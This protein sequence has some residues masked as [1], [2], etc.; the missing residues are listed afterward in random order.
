MS[1]NEVTG[2]SQAGFSA[3]LQTSC[4]AAVWHKPSFSQTGICPSLVLLSPFTLLSL[5]HTH[6]HT[7][8]RT[9]WMPVALCSIP[10][11]YV[12]FVAC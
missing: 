7:R 4:G 9:H 12:P 3:A 6:I 10:N 11:S 2:E 1:P 8:T 5:V